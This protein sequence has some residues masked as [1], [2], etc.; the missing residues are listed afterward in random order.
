MKI[1]DIAASRVRYGYRR[2]HVLLVREGWRANHKRVYRLYREMNL[3][4]RRRTPKRRVRAKIRKY[5]PEV[6]ATNECWSMDFVSDMLFNRQKFRALTIIDNHTRQ[7]VGIGV[8]SSF[9]GID[10]VTFLEEVIENHGIPDRI[11]VDNGPEFISKDVDLW[12]YQRDVILDFCRP[13]TP[14]DNP[15][16]ESFNS[17]FRKECLNQN[18]FLS[19]PDAKEKIEAWRKEYNEIRPHSSLKNRTPLEYLEECRKE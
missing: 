5:Q 19:L 10:V 12:A 16:I 3:Q 15:F 6:K 18:W 17:S 14:T 8:G 1:Q 13:G 4:I 11:K 9:K 7:C 2:I